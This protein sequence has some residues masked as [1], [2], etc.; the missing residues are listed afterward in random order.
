MAIKKIVCAITAALPA[1]TP[2][3]NTA[4]ISAIIKNIIALRIITLNFRSGIKMSRKKPC[5]LKAALK[6]FQES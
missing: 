3:P 1:I 6:S 2:N 4:A 5:R